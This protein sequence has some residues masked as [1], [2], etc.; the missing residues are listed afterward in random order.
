MLRQAQERVSEM[1]SSLPCGPRMRVGSSTSARP[2]RS[3]IVSWPA[4]PGH[5][6]LVLGGGPAGATAGLI[7]ARAGWRVAIAEKSAFPRRK[8]C[9]EFISA[10]SLSLLF[11]L[12]IGDEFLSLA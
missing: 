10:T 9:G 2:A 12:G 1:R 7:L 3:A 11:A 8:V 4:M 5:D 6:A